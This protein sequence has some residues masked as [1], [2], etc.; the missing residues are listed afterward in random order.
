MKVGLFIL[1]FLGFTFRSGDT[2]RL[3]PLDQI[4]QKIRL[5]NVYSDLAKTDFKDAVSEEKL[6]E[7]KFAVLA[8]LLK[9]KSE[10]IDQLQTI[11]KFLKVEPG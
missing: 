8:S 7:M 4:N 6:L 11:G 2:F 10:L 5:G 1:L 3:P 9:M